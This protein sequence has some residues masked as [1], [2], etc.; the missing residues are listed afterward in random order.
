[1]K[2]RRD[3]VFVERALMFQFFSIK[4]ESSDSHKIHIFVT[5]SERF[6]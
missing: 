6:H 4:P 3:D 1:M 2:G 5:I